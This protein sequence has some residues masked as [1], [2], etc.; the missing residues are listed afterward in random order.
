M[1][2]EVVAAHPADE[3]PATGGGDPGET[4]RQAIRGIERGESAGDAARR[5]DELAC[6][7]AYECGWRLCEDSLRTLEA[8]RTRAVAL[9]SVTIIAGGAVASV[10]LSGGLTEDFGCAGVLGWIAFAA[11][12]AAVTVCTAVVAWP[13]TTETALRPAKIIAHYVTPQEPGRRPTWVHKNLASDLD[14][15]FGD[16]TSTL[17]T[18]NRFYKWSI[19]GALVVLAGVGMVV[20]DVVL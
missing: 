17:V 1:S 11:G 3:D 2:D 7:L 10:F 18:R 12:T 14:R 19:L 13:I 5:S 4:E 20:L 8:Q 16:M 6:K 15:A 9:M